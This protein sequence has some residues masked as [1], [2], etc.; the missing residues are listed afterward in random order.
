MRTSAK[1]TTAFVLGYL[2]AEHHTVFKANRF[3]K[4]EQE[5]HNK[6]INERIDKY[7]ELIEYTNLVGSMY[8]NTVDIIRETTGDQDLSNY[9]KLAKIVDLSLEQNKFYCVVSQTLCQNDYK[10]Q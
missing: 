1:I 7:N 6:E 10:E 4:D 2:L 9:E 8:N 5:R 3:I